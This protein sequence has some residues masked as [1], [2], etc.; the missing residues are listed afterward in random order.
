MF[1]VIVA[2]SRNFNDYQLLKTKLDYYLSR[3]VAAG[4]SIVII[5]GTANGADT[6]GEL[7]ATEKRYAIKRYP[8]NWNK[9]GK[10]AG[11]IRNEEMAKDADAAIIFWDGISKGSAHM[12]DIAK[13]KKL[14]LKVVRY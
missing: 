3:K 12:I 14:S 13:S 4:E 1:K 6:L 11:Y 5:S 7:Y 8:A 2:G 10:R 9:Y